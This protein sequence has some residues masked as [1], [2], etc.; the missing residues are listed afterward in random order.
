MQYIIIYPAHRTRGVKIQVCKAFREFQ[1][2]QQ[3]R[4]GIAGHKSCLP[5]RAQIFLW[6]VTRRRW[7]GHAGG[8]QM[9]A[10]ACG[11]Q[12]IGRRRGPCQARGSP[13]RSMLHGPSRQVRGQGHLAAWL[14][15]KQYCCWLS[16]ALG[17]P[18]GPAACL[19]KPTDSQTC[20]LK[21]ARSPGHWPYPQLEN[22]DVCIFLSH[23]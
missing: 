9:V 7:A 19:Q 21:H 22:A 17:A 14:F 12:P 5:P 13:R 4:D 10:V 11:P 8:V 23:T 16:E 6:E 15:C 1:G 20:A 3:G 18:H 2:L